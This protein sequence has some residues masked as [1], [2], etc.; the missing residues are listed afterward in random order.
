MNGIFWTVDG[1][2]K[3]SDLD[4]ILK[5]IDYKQ[6]KTDYTIVDSKGNVTALAQVFE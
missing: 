3:T 5:N 2:F 1:S 4:Y 6:G